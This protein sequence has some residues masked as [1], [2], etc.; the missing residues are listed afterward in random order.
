MEVAIC[1]VMLA[2]KFADLAIGRRNLSSIASFPAKRAKG[3]SRALRQALRGREIDA[4]FPKFFARRFASS[5]LNCGF[6]GGR[7]HLD[8]HLCQDLRGVH[9][10]D[11]RPQ[12]NDATSGLRNT[13]FVA[14]VAH[15]LAS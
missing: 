4:E 5:S 3:L 9:G 14:R 10:N 13:E 12:R 1:V 11:N 2:L 7:D 15:G 6:D 8:S